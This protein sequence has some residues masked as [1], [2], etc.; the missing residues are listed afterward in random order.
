MKLIVLFFIPLFFFCDSFAQKNKNT[1]Y[2]SYDIVVN[3]FFNTYSSLDIKEDDQIKFE[4]KP[5]G[6]HINTTDG[7]SYKSTHDE[8]FWS[9]VNNGFQKFNLKPDRKGNRKKIMKQTEKNLKV[10]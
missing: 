10:F 4:K 8:L 1:T 2:P 9:K 3:K 6:W 7:Y 5:D